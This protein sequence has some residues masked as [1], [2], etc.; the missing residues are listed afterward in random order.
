MAWFINGIYYYDS[1]E[2]AGKPGIQSTPRGINDW[3]EDKPRVKKKSLGVKGKGWLYPESCLPEAT[4]DYFDQQ[5]EAEKQR[6]LE[7]AAKALHAV[8]PAPAAP[9]APK[10]VVAYGT[11]NS[12]ALKDQ[13]KNTRDARATV[14]HAIERLMDDAG[15]CK[16]KAMDMLLQLAADGLLQA[17]VLAALKQA[18]DPRGKKGQGG[19]LPSK[20]TLKRWLSQ[21]AA[22]TLAPRLTREPES[23]LNVPWLP[24]FLARYR[25]PAK[26]T[27]V[28]AW[29]AMVADLQQIGWADE[30]IPSRD[31]MYR[32]VNKL[33]VPIREKGR[34]TGAAW[35]ALRPCI[36]RD[37]SGLRS[38]EVW[39]GDGH[40]FKA[41]VQH[42]DHGRPFAPEVTLI[43]DA[44]SRYVV[45]WTVSLSENCIAVAEALGHA[46]SRHG[47]PLIYYSDNGAGQTGKMLDAPVT[48]ILARTGVWHE[49]GIPGN[50]QGR[51]IIER[52]WKTITIPLART[53]PTC[54]TATM[55]RE[56]LNKVAREIQSA[57]K[58][59]QVPNY[60]P[61]W[62]QFID[63]LDAAIEDYNANHQH[64][65]LGRRT[66]ASV[67]AEKLDPLTA[68]P[69]TPD[70]VRDLFRPEVV[71]TPARGE[72]QLFNNR[73]YLA[74]LADLNPGTQV[75]V[76]YDIHD[77]QTVWIKD[78]EGRPIGE[79]KWNGN[80]KDAFPK[81]V[82]EYLKEERVAGMVGRAQDKI[83]TARAELGRT[84]EVIPEVVLP[85]DLQHAKARLDKAREEQA[86]ER[87]VPETHGAEP[88]SQDRRRRTGVSPFPATSPCRKNVMPTAS[89]C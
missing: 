28:E 56:T 89:G 7:E 57:L 54:Q 5:R 21:A 69:L 72:V 53:F 60:V 29:K 27:K 24:Y 40:T 41:K 81:P 1:L 46:M 77:A 25:L 31:A 37:W 23:Y 2:L 39:V 78:M 70:E 74:D 36:R 3:G 88:A 8:L 80:L 82:I 26:P 63:A 75:R 10:A 34:A 13:Q 11:A 9:K 32:V 79:A 84:L 4:L 14:L 59:G 42:P 20:R 30:D 12:G 66:P 64:R 43:I 83:D 48:G 44:P 73:Y 51:G 35:K 87:E 17:D 55:D 50:P 16:E 18:R 22:G 86:R 45:G 38:N 33:P 6:K 49:T 47:K 15:C 65:E 19:D 68:I 62:K 61:T 58:K 52:I 85:L 67:Y 76:A 71:R